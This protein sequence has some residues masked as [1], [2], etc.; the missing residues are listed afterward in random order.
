MRDSTDEFL[1]IVRLSVQDAI[2]TESCESVG[3]LAFQYLQFRIEFRSAL[4]VLS[5]GHG[6]IVNLL[7]S[8]KGTFL[9]VY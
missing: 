2:Q 5:H 1:G 9:E 8:T 6:S 7:R 3:H 4:T